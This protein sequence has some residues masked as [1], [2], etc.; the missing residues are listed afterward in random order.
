MTALRQVLLAMALACG[1]GACDEKL[2]DVAGPSPNLEPTLSSI[3]AEIFDQ[4]DGTGRRACVTCHAGPQPPAGLALTAGSSH[5]SL[6]GQP[7]SLKPGAIRVVPGDPDAS[8]LVQKLEGAT[9]IVG[10][11]MPFTGG[12]YLTD[13]QMRIIRRWIELGARND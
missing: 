3:Q 1:A 4:T 13:G 2:S 7:S 6:V 10:A 9:G 11:R 5:G 12:P 8:Y